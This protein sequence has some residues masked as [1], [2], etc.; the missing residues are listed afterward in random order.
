MSSYSL[1]A[2]SPWE[3]DLPPSRRAPTGVFY[4]HSFHQCRLR[5]LSVSF[6]FAGLSQVPPT[7]ARES[8]TYAALDLDHCPSTGYS[9]MNLVLRRMEHLYN[10]R[11][12][13]REIG[14]LAMPFGCIRIQPNLK[15]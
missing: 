4:E 15:E 12:C 8:Q 6:R 2:L 9:L 14:N 11:R 10:T 5:Y 1:F 13:G 3:Y 7:P